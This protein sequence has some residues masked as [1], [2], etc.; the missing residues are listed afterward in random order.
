MGTVMSKGKG[1]TLIELLVVIA[2]I[3]LLLS[4]L[5]PTLSKV[6]QQAKKRVC[7]SNLRQQTYAFKMYVDD[8]DDSFPTSPGYY[9]A[10]G[11][12]QGTEIEGYSPNLQPYFRARLLNPYIGR[13]EEVDTQ[14]EDSN[15]KVFMC[16]ADRG[17][18]G[19]TREAASGMNRLPTCWDTLGYSYHYNCSALSND[20]VNGLF[21]KKV[22]AVQNPNQLMLV[23][24]WTMTTYFRNQNPHQYMYWH[25]RK[26]MGWTNVVFVDLHMEFFRMTTPDD[27]DYDFQHGPGWTALF[28]E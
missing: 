9:Y 14:D 15:L 27:P 8:Y 6:R 24:D 12:K 2:I 21:G 18:Y 23:G 16:P 3:A 28:T 10:W 25:N 1:F 20:Y 19:G 11:G 5:I 17:S 4:I 7:Q 26:E 13:K 22:S